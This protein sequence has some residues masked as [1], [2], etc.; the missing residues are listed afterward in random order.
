MTPFALSLAELAAYQS[1]HY[2]YAGVVFIQGTLIDQSRNELVRQFLATDATHLLMLDTDLEFRFDLLDKLVAMNEKAGCGWFN[3]RIGR[4]S[5]PAL[6][7][8]EDEF[9]S[10]LIDVTTETPEYFSADMG[11]SGAMFMH[12]EVFERMREGGEPYWFKFTHANGLT[13]TEDVH[14]CQLLRQYGYRLMVCRDAQMRHW[15]VQ[16]L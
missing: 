5:R 8:F 6:M 1:P 3:I 4:E 15:K 2:E 14:F 10:T 9:H 11:P 13:M 16:A 12:R 7:R